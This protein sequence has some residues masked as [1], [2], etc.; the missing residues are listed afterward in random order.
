MG[1]E[2]PY[3]FI[4]S[5]D[6]RGDFRSIMP[7][8]PIW[9]HLIKEKVSSSK[10]SELNALGHYPFSQY[11]RT[12]ALW[13]GEQPLPFLFQP[14]SCLSECER[15]CLDYWSPFVVRRNE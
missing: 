1:D 2:E 11:C 3:G 4:G 14:C 9:R 13:L 8:N 7:E 10:T 12:L 15:K 6:L 5:R